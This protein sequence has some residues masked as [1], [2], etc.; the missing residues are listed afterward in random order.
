MEQSKSALHMHHKG[1]LGQVPI[2]LG[3]LF[4]M[5][6]YMDDWKVLPMAAVIAGMVAF[7]AAKNYGSTMEGT[8]FGSLAI[9]CICI[10]N[11]FFNSIQVVCR[12]RDIVKR[13]HR[14]GMHISSYIMAHMIY[15]AFLCF[16]Q[17]IIT[18]IVC[19]Y[20][21]LKFPAQGVIFDNI[22]I[23]IGITVFLITYSSDMLS[24]MISCFVKNTTAAM[25]VMPFMLIFELLFSG[26]V[27]SLSDT[28][29]PLT[30][31]SIAKWG[32]NCLCAQGQ[33]NSLP[34]V[35]VWNQ[36]NNFQNVEMGGVY[37]IK[38]V[39]EEM[40]NQGKVEQFNQVVGSYSQKA[41]YLSSVGN[42]MG[43]WANLFLFAVIFALIAILLLEKVDRDKR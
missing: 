23:E 32:I 36:I 22:Y 26:S 11:G 4:R 34:M 40:W 33:F 16:M 6:I 15:Q 3:K 21:G 12:E 19:V 14:G 41:E 17:T 38:Q 20:A 30:N 10:W 24:L 35:T 9:T 29:K 25:T 43:C 1:R 37:P 18:V 13:E 5:F 2:Y 7:I 27:F 8:G 31:L 39:V 42:V 28:I